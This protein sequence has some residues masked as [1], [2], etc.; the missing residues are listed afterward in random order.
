[1]KGFR[2]GNL[3][4]LKRKFRL[5]LVSTWA[6]CTNLSAVL[7]KVVSRLSEI[8]DLSY[9]FLSFSFF[10]FRFFFFFFFFDIVLSKIIVG[11]I[12]YSLVKESG[13]AKKKRSK[14]RRKDDL[15]LSGYLKHL[16]NLEKQR[17]GTAQEI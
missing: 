3:N 8:I 17:L 2:V 14:T 15:T 16:T 9:S 7:T 5:G 6:N 4:H 11:N 1:M 12:K 13:G 10:A